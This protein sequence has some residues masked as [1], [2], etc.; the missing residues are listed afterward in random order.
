MLCIIL[1]VIS[2]LAAVSACVFT[3]GIIQKDPNIVIRRV[4]SITGYCNEVADDWWRDEQAKWKAMT[5]SEKR[6]HFIEEVTA[7]I[8][9]ERR[10]KQKEYC[11]VHAH[12]IGGKFGSFIIYHLNR[13]FG[14]S[15]PAMLCPNDRV[16]WDLLRDKGL[17]PFI[18]YGV[19]GALS[20]APR[21]P[22]ITIPIE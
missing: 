12:Y 22:F 5:P 11:A 13:L 19:E 2:V 8:A 16:C 4:H 15:F 10:S 7:G 6:E 9:M 14:W 21:P 20:G 18:R 17:R 3:L 1:V